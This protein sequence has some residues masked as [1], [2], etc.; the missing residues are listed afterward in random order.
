MITAGAFFYS[1]LSFRQHVCFFALSVG[2]IPCVLLLEWI[3]GKNLMNVRSN[4][5]YLAIF[6]QY[7]SHGILRS[8][9][10]S[11]DCKSEQP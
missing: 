3:N 9:A 6:F 7:E 1:F 10:R 8:V 5:F 2:W 4:I 11:V